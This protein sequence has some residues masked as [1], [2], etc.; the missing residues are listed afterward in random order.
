MARTG[1]GMSADD[2]SQK[3]GVSRVTIARMES[4]KPVAD[5]SIAAVEKALSD[6]GA[7]FTHRKGKVGVEVPE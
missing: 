2:L 7:D 6:A 4:G 3:S 1:L 5:A